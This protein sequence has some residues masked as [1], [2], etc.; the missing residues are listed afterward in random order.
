MVKKK[1]LFFEHVYSEE[2]VRTVRWG[3]TR[4][5]SHKFTTRSSLCQIIIIIMFVCRS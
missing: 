5:T 4:K 2:N 3:G 1:S